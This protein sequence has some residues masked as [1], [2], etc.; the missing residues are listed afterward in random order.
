MQED[1]SVPIPGYDPAIPL[2]NSRARKMIFA[3][4]RATANLRR[5]LQEIFPDDPRLGKAASDLDWMAEWVVE[6]PDDHRALRMVA[7]ILTV[8]D[9]VDALSI[10]SLKRIGFSIRVDRNS[11]PLE[12]VGSLLRQ[13]YQEWYDDMNPDA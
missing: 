2:D 6:A 13:E 12:L 1:F 11:D 8:W 9:G 5:S 3:L 10:D 7:Q 4:L